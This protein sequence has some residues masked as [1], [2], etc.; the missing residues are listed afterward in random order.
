MQNIDLS[1]CENR[2]ELLAKAKILEYVHKRQNVDLMPDYDLT[3]YQ[4]AREIEYVLRE[5][6]DLS[7]IYTHIFSF[8]IIEYGYDLNNGAQ[9]LLPGKRDP[10]Y[11]R[12]DIDRINYRTP[13]VELVGKLN[14]ES[15]EIGSSNNPVVVI[16]FIGLPKYKKV[17][18]YWRLVLDALLYDIEGDH[19]M[20]F[21][22]IFSSIERLIIDYFMDKI[23]SGLYPEYRGPLKHISL[24]DKLRVVARS[25]GEVDLKRIPLWSSMFTMFQELTDRRNQI[26]HSLKGKKFRS[27][28]V[29]CVFWLY[30]VLFAFI[31]HNCK[32]IRNVYLHYEAG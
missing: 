26:A 4:G 30:L 14:G 11:F 24:E 13:I 9:L 10:A 32:T 31:Y 6:I 8:D 15:S 21:F 1:W 12:Y 23:H 27:K 16:E 29:A 19:R 3:S 5:T 22:I 18:F 28:D 2:L 7:K 20:A 17:G 25:L